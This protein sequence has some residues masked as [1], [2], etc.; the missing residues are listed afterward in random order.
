MPL[1]IAPHLEARRPLVLRL[2]GSGAG[3]PGA[4]RDELTAKALLAEGVTAEYLA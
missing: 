3:V 1:V 2:R 4:R